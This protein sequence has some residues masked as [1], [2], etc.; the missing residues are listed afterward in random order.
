MKKFV[1]LLSVL[2]SMFFFAQQ[3]SSIVYR[4]GNEKLISDLNDNLTPVLKEY[5]FNGKAQVVFE[6]DHQGKINHFNILPDSEDSAF[7]REVYRAVL[8]T[9]KNWSVDVQNTITNGI[10]VIIPIEYFLDVE[11]KSTEGNNFLNDNKI[12]LSR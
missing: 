8:R 7:K 5:N 10:K 2:F 12:L 9:Q 4:G 6:V 3:Q 1:S 11:D